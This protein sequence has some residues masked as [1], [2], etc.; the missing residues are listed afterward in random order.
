MTFS[1]SASEAGVVLIVSVFNCSTGLMRMFPNPPSRL[2]MATGLT[3]FSWKT[4]VTS[5]S[6]RR[7]AANSSRMASFFISISSLI[8]EPDDHDIGIV[9][10]HLDNQLLLGSRPDRH[11]TPATARAAG[12]RDLSGNG[13]FDFWRCLRCRH[14]KRLGYWPPRRR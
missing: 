14:R 4:R 8:D 13:S 7:P 12:R 6:A 5:S 1:T 3:Y 10:K 2:D 9:G 11:S